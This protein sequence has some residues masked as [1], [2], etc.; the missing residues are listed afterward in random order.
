ME[1][2]SGLKDENLYYIK[3]NLLGFSSYLSHFY[4]LWFDKPDNLWRNNI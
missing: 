3:K 4:Y 2:P 1:N